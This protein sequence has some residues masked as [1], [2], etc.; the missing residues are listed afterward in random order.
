MIVLISLVVYV[1]SS[2]KTEAR[3]Q[4]WSFTFIHTSVWPLSVETV[5][6]FD[7]CDGGIIES[8]ESVGQRSYRSIS[9]RW[10]CVDEY[11]SKNG[12]TT[13][14]AYRY[15]TTPSNAKLE[16][17]AV[18]HFTDCSLLSREQRL[19]CFSERQTFNPDLLFTDALMR[20]GL[21]SE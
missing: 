14:V 1:G 21:S 12:S 11:R 9:G 5:P 8:G 4:P 16:T 19:A 15:R 17:A 20:S 18:I 2:L 13:L 3:I 6:P 7:R 10:Y